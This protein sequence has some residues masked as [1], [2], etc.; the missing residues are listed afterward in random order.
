M[1]VHVK[2]KVDKTQLCVYIYEGLC[3]LKIYKTDRL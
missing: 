1:H 2:H 3:N